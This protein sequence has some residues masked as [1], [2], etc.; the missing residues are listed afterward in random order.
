M[1]DKKK[2]KREDKL[3][4]EQKLIDRISDFLVLNRKYILTVFAAVVVVIVI[5][6]IATA[7]LKSSRDKAFERVMNLSDKA[8]EAIQDE[9]LDASTYI[10]E[11]SKEIK[12]S[13]YASVKAAYTLGQIYYS[14]KDYKSAYEAFMNAYNL[15]NG[16]YLAPLALINAAASAEANG[17][18]NRA[19][20][21]YNQ[22]A[23]MKE[24]GVEAKAMFNSARIS[25]QQND[26]AL[27]KA[28]L[29]QL[30]DNCP[31]S[32]YALLAKNMLN[33]L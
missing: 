26:N 32:E 13:S 7:A 9:N 31:N 33:V 16:I 12:G 21:I 28:Y 3:T 27:A 18:V 14:E 29:Q 22:V 25:I 6:V 1:A 19:Q 30:V 11:I 20:E 8:A 23:D 4:A 15:N 10:E 2:I 17:D 24:S 5:A